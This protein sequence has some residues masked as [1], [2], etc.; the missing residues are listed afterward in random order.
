MY[1]ATVHEAMAG[2]ETFSLVERCFHESAPQIVIVEGLE[3]GL[4]RSPA[5]IV[6]LINSVPMEGPWPNGEAFFLARLAADEHVPFVGAEPGDRV[7]L[8][9]FEEGG[10]TLED[11]L[12]Y[13]LTR[14]IPQWRRE[15]RTEPLESL[16]DDFVAAYLEGVNRVGAAQMTIESLA[17]WYETKNG[18]SFVPEN[19]DEIE[20]API[21]DAPPLP[22]RDMALLDI[23]VRDLA[24]LTRVAIELRGNQ[25]VLIAYGFGHHLTQFHALEAMLGPGELVQLQ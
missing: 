24:I 11:V 1:V 4:G 10:Y 5:H 22:T 2:T 12:G 6:D 19:I 18:R 9:A 13:Q 17:R 3:T 23:R 7:V 14:Q 15:S 20:T 25:S 16:V 21:A 8:E